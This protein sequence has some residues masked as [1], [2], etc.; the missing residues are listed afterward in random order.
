MGKCPEW[1]RPIVL[2][3][4]Y[5][6][7]RRGEILNLTR[8]QV[9]PSTRMI[10]LAPQ[11]TKE[12]HWKRIPIHNELVPMLEEAFKVR[13]LGTDQVFLLR[14]DKGA[15]PLA[16]ETIR[17]PWPRACEALESSQATAGVSR[18]TP[19]VAHQCPALRHGPADSGEHHGPLVPRQ[20][21][22][23]AVRPDLR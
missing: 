6:G 12:T 3:S 10:V 4:Y 5:T 14:D 21:G 9:N 19:Y 2:T 7:M 13:V 1:F 17:N 23:R 11:D 20:D 15:R 18:S 16:F 22:Q 8:Q